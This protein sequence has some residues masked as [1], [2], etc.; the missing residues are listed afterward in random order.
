MMMS[1]YVWLPVDILESTTRPVQNS[2]GGQWSDFSQVLVVP[3][4]QQVLS[5][6]RQ[7]HGWARN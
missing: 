3:G 7:R 6:T 2:Q 1:T 5:S 4:R